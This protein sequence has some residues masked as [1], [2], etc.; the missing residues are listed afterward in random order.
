MLT[1]IDPDRTETVI[2]K[3]T[4][5]FHKAHPGVT[6]AGCGCSLSI[7]SRERP[8]DE[9]AAIK[10]KRRADEEDRILAQA[11]AIRARRGAILAEP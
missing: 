3:T 9:V 8:A 11:D 2:K 5:L 1:V 6:F 7:T 10:A 4:C